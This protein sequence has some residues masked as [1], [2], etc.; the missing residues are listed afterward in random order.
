MLFVFQAVAYFLLY[1]Q[2]KEE[3]QEVNEAY[4]QAIQEE[5]TPHREQLFSDEEISKSLNHYSM[6][7]ILA[8][9]IVTFFITGMVTF[10]VNKMMIEPIKKIIDLNAETDIENMKFYPEKDLPNN[11]LGDIIENRDKMLKEM[12]YKSA[13][14]KE[15][16][17]MAGAIAHEINTPLSVIFVS[18]QF[19]QLLLSKKS[20][21]PEKLKKEAEKIERT[22]KAVK[23][24]SKG[25][26][27]LS[28]GQSADKDK[29]R[30]HINEIIKGA[31]EFLSSKFVMKSV[32][33]EVEYHKD[34]IAIMG[35]MY[36]LFQVFLNVLKNACEAAGESEEKWVKV[37]LSSKGN[38]VA[39][40]II[41]SGRGVKKHDVNKVFEHHFS[42]KKSRGMGL[43]LSLSR[44]FVEQHQ[45]IIFID[46]E[47]K[48][49]CFEIRLPIAMEESNDEE[50]AA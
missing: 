1:V 9:I 45:G 36:Q 48:Y 4:V 14:F 17:D 20:L 27:L 43:G 29:E 47:S 26:Q 16:A 21:N 35:H 8:L 30:L 22:V 39:I 31:V 3:Y 13:R 38:Y 44:T 37:S 33:V 24:I 18:S 46:L 25:I 5:E 40:R 49:T 11:E 15:L 7:I 19:M 28:Q 32:S 12:F 41:D 10:V 23:K 50:N 6:K 2:E 34:N 42:T